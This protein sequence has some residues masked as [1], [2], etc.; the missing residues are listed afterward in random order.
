[1]I[2]VVCV[3]EREMQSV[4][5]GRFQ[6][7]Q[8]G[9]PSTSYSREIYGTAKIIWTAAN[10]SSARLSR[11]ENLPPTRVVHLTSRCRCQNASFTC[12]Y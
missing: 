11:G 8:T 10:R 2:G 1:M 5:M 6:V 3:Q 4:Q 12:V 9:D 7:K